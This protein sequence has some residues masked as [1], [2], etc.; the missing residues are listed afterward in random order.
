MDT[1]II[2][3]QGQGE[4]FTSEEEQALQEAGEVLRRGGLVAFPTETV[5]GLG[6][7]ALNPESSRKIYAAKGRPSDN[8]LIIHIARMEDLAPIVGQVT[9]EAVLLAQAFWPGPLT[10]VL[11]KSESV[12]YETTGGLDTVAVRMPSHPVARRLIACGGGYVAAPSANLS[13]RPSPTSAKYVIED[14]NGRVDIIIDGGEGDIGLESTIVDL[15]VSPPQILRPGYITQNMLSEVLG[16]ISVDRTILEADSGQAPRAPGMKYRHYAPKGELTIISGPAGQV[17]DYINVHAAE[18]REQGHKVG[19]IGTDEVLVQYRADVVRSLGSRQD[20]ESIARHLYSIL[21]EFDDEQVTRI[22]SE[23]FESTG[24]GQ[25][26]MN[27]L[28]KAAGHKLIAL[29]S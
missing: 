15:T 29:E 12:P 19:V 18:D 14:M 28:L 16:Q 26:I 13:G 8:P 21:R 4:L 17:T 1:K 11:H 25:A 3:I 6:G 22:Y 23:C 2:K 9:E 27:R 5:Y 7:D 10:M 24:L 20:E